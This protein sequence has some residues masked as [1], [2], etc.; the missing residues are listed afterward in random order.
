MR[1]L[2][3]P[4]D[5]YGIEY[6]INPWMHR[7]HGADR[8]LA[9]RQWQQLRAQFLELGCAVDLIAPQPGLP[10]M[11]FTANAGLICGGDAVP[12][13]FRHRERQGE[14]PHFTRWFAENGFAVRS[15]PADL[16]F[17]GEG[18]ALFCG[19]TL[20]C[21]YRYRSDIRS[22]RQLGE[23][24]RCLTISVEL[25]DER[26]YHLDT[27]F[28]PLPGGG[29]AWFPPAFDAYGQSAIRQHCEFLIDVVP[30]EAIRFACN[31]V[32]IGKNVVLSEGCPRLMNELEQR[33]YRC[34]P[35]SMTEFIKSGGSCKCLT[36]LVPARKG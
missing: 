15:L 32:V 17:E 9:S 16:V 24:F 18:D 12:S 7:E 10:D 14:A 33:G 35:L 27:C 1:L 25:V 4:P 2:L 11:V 26:F 21:G 28:C 34:H 13:N 31:A 36:L 19:E 8:V 20:F 29:A 3:C 30:E 23:W 6:E 5:F 22:R